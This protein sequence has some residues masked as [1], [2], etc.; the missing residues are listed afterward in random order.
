MTVGREPARTTLPAQL[1]LLSG[2]RGSRC[3]G[4]LLLAGG[5]PELDGE[6]GKLRGGGRRQRRGIVVL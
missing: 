2:R 3:E 5:P 4:L 1:P 6:V